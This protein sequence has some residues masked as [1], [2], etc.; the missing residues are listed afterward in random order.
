MVKQYW[1]QTSL[2]AQAAFTAFFLILFFAGVGIGAKMATAA[3]LKPISIVQGETLKVS[4]LFEGVTHN[5]DYVI[6]AAPQ[7]GQDMTLNARTLYRIA[8]S[9]DLPW[10]P[11]STSD[12]ITVRRQATFISS[13]IIEDTMRKALIDKGVSG[14]FNV[15]FNSG[16]PSITLPND[17][18]ENIEISAIDFDV[19]KDIFRATLV[20]PSLDNPV[21]K[22]QVSGMVERIINVPVLRTNLQNGDIISQHDIQMIEVPQQS[23]QHN[24]LIDPE[25]IIGLTPRRI[26]YAGKFIL[27][28]TLG[29]PLLVDRGDKIN[30]TFQE[31][32]LVLTAKGR[33]LESGAK[34]DL[35][36]VTNINSSRTVDAIVVGDHQVMAQ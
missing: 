17:L 22:V 25:E 21:K 11:L 5:A 27:D 35:I 10:R 29:R 6:G 23:L 33:A 12:Q 26:A 32:P 30:I 7:P 8:V 3:T 24:V 15:A 34:G 19:Q 1:S 9:L 28:G 31:G 20:A 4:D 16:K 36:R 18:P 13:D 2:S 14:K